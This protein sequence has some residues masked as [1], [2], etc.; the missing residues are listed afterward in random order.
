MTDD[1]D[2]GDEGDMTEEEEEESGVRVEDVVS[3]CEVGSAVEKSML[4]GPLLETTVGSRGL[5]VVVVVVAV[6]VDCPFL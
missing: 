3:V 6:V 5:A 4:S 2:D 1:D